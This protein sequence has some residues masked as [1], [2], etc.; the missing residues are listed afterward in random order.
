MEQKPILAAVFTYQPYSETRSE[1]ERPRLT[2]THWALHDLRRT[3]R[4]LPAKFGCPDEVGEAVI[5]HMPKRIVGGYNCY[6][7]DDQRM[8]WLERLYSGLEIAGRGAILGLEKIN[9]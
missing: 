7:Y 9:G 8:Y 3:T 5:K 6:D 1:W 4:T 2:V